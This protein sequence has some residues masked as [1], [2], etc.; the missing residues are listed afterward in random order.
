MGLKNE[1]IRKCPERA[2]SPSASISVPGI[3][4][5]FAEGHE[6]FRKELWFVPEVGDRAAEG[7]PSAVLSE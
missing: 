7:S 1:E 4:Q 3:A 5:A 2:E 6:A